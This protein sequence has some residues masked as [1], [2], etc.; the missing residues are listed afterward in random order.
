MWEGLRFLQELDAETNRVS[1]GVK[2]A[3]VGGLHDSGPPGIDDEVLAG[4][5]IR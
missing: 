1:T 5:L 2:G 4:L 3:A